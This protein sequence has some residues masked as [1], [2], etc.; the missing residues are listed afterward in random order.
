VQEEL[1]NTSEARAALE[2]QVRIL[3][4]KNDTIT[5][6][7]ASIVISKNEQ[8]SEIFGLKERISY[9]DTALKT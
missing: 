7:M 1:R 8:S 3:N 5:S 9:L 6:E 2:E 4:A